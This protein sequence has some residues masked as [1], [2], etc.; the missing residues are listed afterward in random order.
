MKTPVKV[1]WTKFCILSLLL[2]GAL[3]PAYACPPEV[4]KAVALLQE[5]A[6]ANISAEDWLVQVVDETSTFND[7]RSEGPLEFISG[8]E[9]VQ[10]NYGQHCFLIN[11]RSFI[12]RNILRRLKFARMTIG[13]R[14]P[15]ESL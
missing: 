14:V 9:I 12:S 8:A 7:V 15:P 6:R 11:C 4:D 2:W 5:S 10:K 3:L 13:V 1:R